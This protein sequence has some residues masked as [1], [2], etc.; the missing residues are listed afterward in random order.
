MPV[1]WVRFLASTTVPKARATPASQRTAPAAE[2]TAESVDS[3]DVPRKR[4]GEEGKK[5]RGITGS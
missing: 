3:S 4:I 1:L 5:S 2:Q